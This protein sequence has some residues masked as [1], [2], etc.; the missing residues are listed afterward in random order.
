MSTTQNAVGEHPAVEH[1]VDAIEIIS[2]NGPCAHARRHLVRAVA[3]LSAV[4]TP[5]VPVQD[6]AAGGDEVEA[7]RATFVSAGWAYLHA[8]A[9]GGVC[10]DASCHRCRTA[11][12]VGEAETSLTESRVRPVAAGGS[13][14]SD[15]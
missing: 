15:E 4:P 1:F 3:A 14:A 13:C 10:S 2:R 11:R 6:T 9:D 12:V 8:I 5:S 7:A